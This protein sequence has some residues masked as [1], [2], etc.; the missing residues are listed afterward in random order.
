[1][2]GDQLDSPAVAEF[3]RA[4]LAD[5]V[6]GARRVCGQVH[7]TMDVYHP[8]GHADP[9]TLARATALLAVVEQLHVPV[10]I[11]NGSKCGT[12][13]ACLDTYYGAGWP[14]ETLRYIANSWPDHPDFDPRWKLSEAE[15]APPGTV[16]WRTPEDER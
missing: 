13:R 9:A 1:M 14:C 3:I 10:G 8:G 4:R 16:P 7:P 2:R 6:A 15:L 11:P 12:C 5:E